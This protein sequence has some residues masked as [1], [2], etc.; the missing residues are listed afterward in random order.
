MWV[1]LCRFHCV[2]PSLLS[3]LRSQSHF[4]SR[5][6]GSIFGST[7]YNLEEHGHTD[8]QLYD[9][10]VASP[11]KFNDLTGKVVAITGT[12]AGG[13]GFYACEVAIKKNAKVLLLLNRDSSSAKKGEEGLKAIVEEI[14]APTKIQS[15]TC[16]MQDMEVVKKAGE[17]V[18]KVADKNGGLD[19]LVCNTGIMATRD[20]RSKDGYEVQMQTNQLSHFLLTSIV[21][22]S[23]VKASESR[24]EARFV[25]HSSSARRVPPQESRATILLQVWCQY[26]R[27]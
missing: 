2:S 15:I 12:S 22:S 9:D 25:T 21:F 14:K 5:R 7:E 3:P 26:T 11:D 16:D 18:N 4:V 8:Q 6:M 10:Y 20:K 1:V 27:W 13:L 19:V 24:G 17:E 23:L